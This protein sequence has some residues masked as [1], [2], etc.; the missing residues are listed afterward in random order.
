VEAEDPVL[1]T[2]FRKVLR[3]YAS[4]ARAFDGHTGPEFLEEPSPEHAALMELR[5]TTQERMR[6]LLRFFP[7]VPPGGFGKDDPDFGPV[8]HPDDMRVAASVQLPLALALGADF[9]TESYGPV[10]FLREK[11]VLLASAIEVYAG[12]RAYSVGEYRTKWQ[13]FPSQ[14]PAR[15]FADLVLASPEERHLARL[16]AN[17]ASSAARC[18]EAV[19]FQLGCSV[20]EL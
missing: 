7:E 19:E 17:V 4:A 14:V 5:D 16:F 8:I 11:C 10:A 18:R 15:A 1:Y 20:D 9:P 2:R 13:G 3:R 6:E 12:W